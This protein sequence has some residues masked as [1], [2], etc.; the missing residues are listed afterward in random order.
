MSMRRILA[1]FLFCAS[2]APASE[3]ES[4]AEVVPTAELRK[5]VFSTRTNSVY[6]YC[7][8]EFSLLSQ[9]ATAPTLLESDTLVACNGMRASVSGMGYYANFEHQNAE[10]VR[11]TI[12]RP[13]T[14]GTFVEYHPIQ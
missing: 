7:Y 8:V 14:G 5:S 4:T 6:A 3:T 11:V 12:V 2:C 13:Q 10:T 9:A 1:V